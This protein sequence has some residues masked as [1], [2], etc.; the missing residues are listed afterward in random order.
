MR[1]G[2]G[3]CEWFF[4]APQMIPPEVQN[5]L[6]VLGGSSAAGIENL[7][8]QI[9]PL[10]VGLIAIRTELQPRAVGCVSVG[11]RCG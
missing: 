1:F 8:F 4:Q 5:G 3:L 10:D 11:D 7:L 6:D 9:G 2:G